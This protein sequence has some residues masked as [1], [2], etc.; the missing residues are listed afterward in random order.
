MLTFKYNKLS[1]LLSFIGAINVL[2]DEMLICYVK[3]VNSTALPI[4]LN[5]C[6]SILLSRIHESNTIL[7]LLSQYSPVYLM[8]LH[9]WTSCL[10]FL[11]HLVFT[12]TLETLLMLFTLLQCISGLLY[13]TSALKHN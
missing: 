13:H 8:L 2:P 4:K 12:T 5:V 3:V 9:D 1:I 7:D 6:L 11:K 10:P